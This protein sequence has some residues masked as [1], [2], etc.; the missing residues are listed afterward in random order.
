[1]KIEFPDFVWNGIGS[2]WYKDQVM[3][4]SPLIFPIFEEFFKQNKIDTI[5]EIGTAYGG[6]SL[7]LEDMTKQYGTRIISYD[8]CRVEDM[9]IHEASPTKIQ[10]SQ[11]LLNSTVDYRIKNTYADEVIQE[12]ED[13]ILTGGRCVV[14]CDGGDKDKEINI[15]AS[16]IKAGDFIFSHDYA[17]NIEYYSQHIQSKYWSWVDCMYPDIKESIESNNIKEYYP[18][19]FE[20]A[21]WFCGVKQ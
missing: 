21:A 10:R 2:I 15:Y 4:Q 8:I 16:K 9:P 18:E 1:M 3:M 14:F 19:I 7:F 17:K 6:F 11:H 12:I 20:K 5:I 13:I